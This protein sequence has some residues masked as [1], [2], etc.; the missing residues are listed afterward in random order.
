M[1]SSFF[2]TPAS[3]RKRKRTNTT[4]S[5]P[6]R[7][8][9]DN[10]ARRADRDDS[11]SGSDESD[12]NGGPVLDESDDDD[13]S[14]DENETAAEKRRRL[15]ERYLDN[16]RNE[17][18]Q[19]VGFDAEQIDK[20]LIAERLKEDA[21]EGKGKIYRAIAEELDFEHAEHVMG[22]SGL[23]KATTGCAV[24]LPYAWTISK[25]LVVE[26]WEIAD[27]KSYAPD[28]TRPSNVTPRRTPKRLFWRKGNK[29]KKGD[30]SYLGHTGEIV[31]I[32]VSDSGKYLA[33]GDKH[34]RLI[35]WDADTLKPRHLFTRHRDAVLSLSFRRGTEQLFSGGADRAVIVWSAPESAYIETLVGHQDAVVGVAGGLETNQE[36]CVSVG[37]RDR[38]ARLWRVVEENQLVFQGG[39]TTRQKGLD[40]L[41]KGRFANGLAKLEETREQPDHE[42]DAPI[43][44]AQGSIDCV[45]LLDAGL[46][47]TASDSGA[48]SLWSVNRKKPLFTYP[49]THGRDP[50]LSPEQ[51]SANHDAAISVKPGPRLPR[52][53]TALAT[54]P[55]ADLILTASWDGWIRAWKI[56][57]DRKS[58]EPVGKIGHVPLDEDDSEAEDAILIRGIVNGLA[59]QERGDRGKDGLCVVAAVG[60]EPRLARWMSGKVKNGIYV[61]EVP[62]K[63]LT[64]N[65]TKDEEE[66]E[67]GPEE[68]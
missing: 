63:H 40:K 38:T 8:N 62:K 26:K 11:I 67:S 13:T 59:I 24:K 23:Q 1:S 2:T 3:Q 44:Y 50:P 48:L 22:Y 39:V 30:R 21:A 56:T 15:A 32:A 66:A 53:V 4:S 35:I 42:E 55:F 51:M 27:P 12:D 45:G 9:T 16:I 58:I 25:D 57:A 52:Y 10:D 54:V 60:K 17:V 68:A 37:A 29:N 28:P 65:G 31:S 46:F 14:E 64:T 34:A 5:A 6:K 7:R 33:T 49:L 43:V 36:T 19:D 41:R 47:V 20:D 61:F 18:E